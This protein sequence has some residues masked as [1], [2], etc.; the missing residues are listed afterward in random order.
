MAQTIDDI[1]FQARQ[2]SVAAIIQIL[3]ARFAD[4]NIRT[5]AVLDQG[6]LQLLCEAPTAE[7]LPQ[8]EVV[9]RV[10]TNLEAISPRGI[11]RVNINGRIVKEQ[12]L[13]WLDEIKRDPLKELL[14]SE[15]ITLKT[16]NPVARL[17]RDLRSPRQRSVY[18]DVPSRKTKA[19]KIAFWRGLIGG[20]SLCLLALIAAWG[21]KDWLGSRLNSQATNPDETVTA[22]TPQPTATAFPAEAP[23]LSAD[24]PDPFTQAVRLAERAAQDGQTASTAADW[25]D[26]ASRWQRA[27]DLMAQIPADDPRYPT[28]QSRVETYRQN[29]KTALAVADQVE[30]EEATQEATQE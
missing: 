3:N 6:I 18:V 16:P 29:S 28:A 9:E 26:L 10:R 4:A 12:Q 5:R 19:G 7:Q 21:M 25:L 15:L 13:L 8:S 1:D 11:S 14:W 30:S 22:A 27:S 23:P 2:G 24:A 17:W 20:A